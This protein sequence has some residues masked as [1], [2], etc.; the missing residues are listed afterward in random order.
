[1]EMD[2]APLIVGER[3]N[4]NGSKK[5]RDLLQKEDYDGMVMMAKEAIKEGAH[6]LDVCVAYVGRNEVRDMKEFVSR[7]NTQVPLP[8]VIDSTE[9]DVIEAALQLCAGK[10]IVNSINL[11]DGEE[12][13]E[14]VVP[15]CKKYGAAVVALTIDERGMAKTAKGRPKKRRARTRRGPPS[16][17]WMTPSP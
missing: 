5:F 15:L 11:E 13:I 17:I 10:A 3:T 12:R 7:L 6:V 16:L 8:L 1:M 9:A 2:P 14:K 4:A